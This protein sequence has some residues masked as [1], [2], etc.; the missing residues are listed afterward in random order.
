MN[1]NNGLGA[2]IQKNVQI[3][4]TRP[5]DVVQAV[6]HGNGR[7]WWII[8]KHSDTSTPQFN[9][10]F[11]YLITPT[12]IAAPIIQD[13]NNATDGDLQKI[14]F[15]NKCNKLMQIN[16]IGFMCE[17]DFDRC[18]GIISNPNMIY[19]EQSANYTRYFWEGTYSPND[20]LF[21]VTANWNNSFQSDTSRLL[22]Y[23]LYAPDIVASCDTLIFDRNPNIYGAVR[24][25]P[26]SK[27]Y[28]TSAYNWGGFVYPYPDSVYNTYNMN[29]GVIND[30]DVDGIG[31]NFQPFSFY[32]GG[33]RTYWGL[34]NNPNY[35]L[36]PLIGSGCDTIPVG[37]HEL[38]PTI[39]NEL[40]ITY[41]NPWQKIFINAQQ[42]KGSKCKI[43]IIDASGK[44]VYSKNSESPPPYFTAEVNISNLQKGLYVVSLT[45]DKEVLVGKFVKY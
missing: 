40:L 44:V 31:C 1:L 18:S 45:T 38:L 35:E 17:F 43:Q 4:N 11:V 24:L 29:L 33:A 2:V 21:Y 19:T 12:G 30:P 6:R 7:D 3:S 25:A 20:S 41:V 42:I 23:N 28:L 39:K 22:Q 36:G 14:I 32:L 9:R 5:G 26:D 8:T 15:N 37:V 27:I 16:F 10:Y 13:F 34:P